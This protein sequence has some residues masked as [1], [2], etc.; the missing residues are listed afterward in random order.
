ML[1]GCVGRQRYDV[2]IEAEHAAAP[3]LAARLDATAHQL[4][5][6]LADRQPQPAACGALAG[7]AGLLEWLKDPLDLVGRDADAGILDLHDEGRKTN[8][9]GRRIIGRW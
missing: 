1:R 8:D 3:Q 7:V 4:D 2:D 5:N 9:K 6:P